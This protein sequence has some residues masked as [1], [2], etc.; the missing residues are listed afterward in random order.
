MAYVLRYVGGYNSLRTT[1]KIS[2]YEDD[3]VGDSE[4]ITIRAR[5]T[6]V[7]Y[8]LQDWEDP[9]IGLTAAFD[10][11]NDRDDFF[12]L[13]PLITAVEGKY[14]IKIERVTPSALILFEGFLQ[15]KD[16]EQKYLQKQDIRLNASSYLS[17]LEFID[18]P[19]IE[20]LENDTFINIIDNCLRQTGSNAAIWVNCSLYPVGTSISNTTTLFNKCGVF[21]ET[22]WKD[23]IVRD[24]ALEV[25]RKILSAFDCYIF[26]FP[27][28][29][30]GTGVWVIDRYADIWRADTIDYVQYDSGVEYWPDDVGTH[31]ENI[32]TVYDFADTD[33]K[34]M[35]TRQIIRNIVGQRQVEI[36]IEQKLLF[37]LIVNNFELAQ[38][39][40]DDLP[41]TSPRSWELYE[42]GPSYLYEGMEWRDLGQPFRNIAKAVNRYGYIEDSAGDVK[43]WHGM[44]TSFWLTVTYHTILTIEFKFATYG[45]PFPYGDVDEWEMDFYWSLCINKFGIAYLVYDESADS[46]SV[47]YPYS[48]E[49]IL[50]VKSIPGT[51]FDPVNHSC[52][53]TISIPF[54]EFM[55]ASDS[56]YTG[57]HLYTFGIG[58]EFRR[59]N[60]PHDNDEAFGSCWYGDVKIVANSPLGE[61]YVS[62]AISTLFLNKKTITQYLC[63]GASLNIKNIIYY[64]GES[65]ADPDALDEKVETW[66]DAHT[67]SDEE[68]S[69]AK[70]RIKDKFR[71]YNVN[72][73]ELSADLL[74]TFNWRPFQRF[75]DTNQADSTGGDGPHFIVIATVYHPD[76]DRCETTMAEYDVEEDI[77][78]N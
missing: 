77:N 33:I 8:T 9:I 64:G 48:P 1:G 39:T 11:V 73:Q 27:G 36:N 58:T 25:I 43:H 75:K 5:T 76:E 65:S 6:E 63:D 17:K 67:D 62:G 59:R 74:N 10:V 38:T 31:I 66:V 56:P 19:T 69:L 57:D 44:Y 15:C 29:P 4:S 45:N 13:L 42:E 37:N 18:P 3:Y 22:F 2:I 50:N 40:A 55:L 41:I 20:D 46:W 26:Y 14:W 49:S 35:D 30:G 51:E 47:E 60:W 61:N 7:R 16:N 24:S 21:K 53:V 23:N 32:P 72:R 52:K 54:S 34:K 12:E 71:L 78:L 68:L 70:I 28:A